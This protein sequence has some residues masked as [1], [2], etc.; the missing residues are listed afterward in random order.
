MKAECEMRRRAPY[1]AARWQYKPSK[2]K[3]KDNREYLT[4]GCNNYLKWMYNA[5]TLHL[6]SL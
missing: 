6:A 4:R 5:K 3:D 2:V 1:V